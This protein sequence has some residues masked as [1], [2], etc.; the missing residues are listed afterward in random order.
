MKTNKDKK[1]LVEQLK[2]TP[3]IQV[4]CEKTGVSRATYYRLIKRDSKFAEACTEAIEQGSAVINDLAE[5]A[6]ISAIQDRNM[7]AILYW[8]RMR[9][10]AYA[11]KVKL[12]IKHE[13]EELTPEQARMVQQA[14]LK[15]GLLSPSQ[16]ETGHG[17]RQS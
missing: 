9:H 10:P 12:D 13:T 4:A 5:A 17:E 14:L 11:A 3:I 15:A 2:K 1:V 6:L 8:L 16:E 7:T